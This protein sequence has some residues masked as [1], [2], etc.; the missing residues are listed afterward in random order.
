MVQKEQEQKEAVARSEAFKKDLILIVSVLFLIIV[1]IFSFIIFKRLKE[2]K[3]QKDII[4]QKNKE[5]TDSIRYA[6]R[7]QQAFMPSEKFVERIM[8]ELKNKKS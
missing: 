1:S 6:K 8:N 4:E 7:I 2:N 5:I 3:K